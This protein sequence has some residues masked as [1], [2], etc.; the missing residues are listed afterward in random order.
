MKE[1]IDELMEQKMDR[2]EFLKLSAVTV[3]SIIGITRFL[4][5][6]HHTRSVHKGYGAGAY[7]GSEDRANYLRGQ[8]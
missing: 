1:E 2:G 4:S 3:A 6:I 8:R 5:A 7:G